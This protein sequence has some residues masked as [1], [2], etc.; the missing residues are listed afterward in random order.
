MIESMRIDIAKRNP[1]L[2]N[3]VGGYSGPGIFPIALRM[4]YQVAHAVNIPVMGMGGIQS[5][6]DVLE[7][8]MAGASAVQIGAANLVNPYICKEI[9]EELPIR[10][11]QLGIKSLREITG[12]AD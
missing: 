11:N 12:T 6:D 3:K 2:A 4:V 7:M 10:M 8:I 5:A 1:I 9:I